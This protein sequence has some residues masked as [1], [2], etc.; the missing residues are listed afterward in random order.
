MKMCSMLGDLKISRNMHLGCG[1]VAM[2]HLKIP[3]WQGEMLPVVGGAGEQAWGMLGSVRM[4][5]VS[6][7]RWTDL[8][9]VKT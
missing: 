9:N 4:H 8:K 2:L 6:L 7:T 3:Q 5:E 1:H